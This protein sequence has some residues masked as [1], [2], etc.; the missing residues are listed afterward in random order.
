MA[1]YLASIYGTEK[2]KVNCSFYFKI[3]AC[4]HGER[5]SRKHVKPTFSQTMLIANMYRTPGQEQPQVVAGDQEDFDL[6]YEDIFTELASFGEVEEMIVCDN[7][8]DHLVGNV[9]CQFRNEEDAGKAVESLN[10]RFYAGRPLYAE[11]SP[12][13]DFR[14][15]CCRQ[16]EIAECNRGGFCN[17][18]H[19]KHPS[20][21]LRRDLQEGQ[22]LTIKEKRR[23]ARQ[24]EDEERQQRRRQEDDDRRRYPANDSR[25]SHHSN[26]RRDREDVA[27]YP[28]AKVKVEDYP[29][30]NVKVEVK[31]EFHDAHSHPVPIRRKKSL[32][33]GG[34]AGAFALG[35]TTFSSS[36]WLF[37]IV[38]LTFFLTSSKLTK[39]KADRKRQLEDEYDQSSERNLVQVVCNGFAGGVTWASE[40]GIL[41]RSWPYLVTKWKRV[42]PGTNGGVSP[43]GLAASLAGGAVIGLASTLSLLLDRRCDGFHWD[44]IILGALAGFGGSMIDSILGATVQ[45]TLYSKEKGMVISSTS[46]KAEVVNVSGWNLLDNHQVNLVSSLLTSGLCGLAALYFSSAT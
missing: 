12:V 32:T 28:G 33:R 14:E 26:E 41:N 34:A 35:M 24:R 37:T 43:L 46:S 5:C 36:Y 31:E 38:L 39:F 9:Y 25:G 44:L 19:L 15:A 2:D 17:F 16:N 4:R 40:L 21:S 11:L 8:G 10:D 42:P 3:G 7:V 6:F 22:R 18:M 23:E 45:E 29:G 13:T 1:E 27:D 30:A 20:R